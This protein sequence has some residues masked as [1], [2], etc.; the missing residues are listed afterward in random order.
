MAGKTMNCDPSQ[1]TIGSDRQEEGREDLRADMVLSKVA[2]DDV[3]GKVDLDDAVASTYISKSNEWD[4]TSREEV[5]DGLKR[6]KVE[7]TS[8]AEPRHGEGVS[9]NVQNLGRP[10]NLEG[11]KKPVDIELVGVGR[12]GAEPT[13]SLSRKR[14]H[15][16]VST[17]SDSLAT[18]CST[19]SK[20]RHSDRWKEMFQKL[21]EYKVRYSCSA[22]LAHA[23]VSLL[24]L[25]SERINLEI[26]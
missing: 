1:P 4:G 19:D 14:P 16:D 23:L 24:T 22:L 26:V 9:Q 8:E 10:L 2:T 7:R 15:D 6:R 17:D 11:E 13:S 21:K 12:N 5:E 18:A 25:L 20:I 3:T